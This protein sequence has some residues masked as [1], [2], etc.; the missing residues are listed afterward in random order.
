MY[1][2]KI[3]PICNQ[4]FQP[5]FAKQKY[6]KRPVELT[7]SVC[8][9]T[10]IG[11]CSPDNVTVCN[12]PE[13][14]KKAAS[15]GATN[16]T[17]I[18]RICGQPFHPN[19][20]RQ[21]D[22][23]RPVTKV[24]VLC[25]KEYVGKCSQNDLSSTCSD[26][27]RIK[28]A[29]QQ[30]MKA[31]S[32]VSTRT[33]ML[34]GKEFHPVNNTQIIC[35]DDHFRTC[36]VCGKEF[37]LDTRY[38]SR[39]WATTCSRNCSAILAN[40]NKTAETNARIIEERRADRY[41]DNP[42][43]LENYNMF[44]K[45]PRGYILSRY[46]KDNPATIYKLCDDFMLHNT[47]VGVLIEKY[48][49]RDLLKMKTSTMEQE[50]MRFIESVSPDI[51]I[52][53]NTR[54][55]ITPYELDIYLPDY[56]FAIEC[57]PTATHNSTNHP[58]EEDALPTPEKYHKM[59]TDMCEPKGIY[60]LHVFG[61][62]WANKK[63]IIK[64][65]IC[66]AIRHDDKIYAR[67]CV[68]KEVNSSEARA[69]L[70]ENHRQGHCGSS[71]R[72]GLYYQDKL[73]S[74]MTFGSPR[75]GIGNNSQ[76]YELLRFCSCKYMSVVGGASKLFKYFIRTYNPSSIISYSDRAHTT[77]NIYKVL[78]FNEICRSD[79]NYRWVQEKTDKDYHRIN[80]QKQN[81]KQ[82]LKDDTIDLSET[83]VK[84]M[85]SHGYVQVFDSGTITWEWTK[86]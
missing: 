1:H 41:K 21:L 72:I 59:K 80:A 67:N 50:I 44:L 26:E 82:F 17:K 71:I 14:K 39:E 43:K 42:D 32:R 58:F 84:I 51:K 86:D 19:S 7:C 16:K 46:S 61:Y 69:F 54:K 11:Q 27:C 40:R 78:G 76:Q 55:I 83:E 2:S 62:D 37:K 22:C 13:C 24:C 63:E 60:L 34:C 35:K 18:C 57:N 64:S 85:A 25:G 15:V 65:I 48:G 29:S 66:N 6:C 12:K 52:V 5:Q 73:V 81:I 4:E 68:I 8:G 79:A 49:L 30:S 47:T 77:G 33:C 36:E 45:D 38:N 23:N 75:R 53:H 31:V 20:S 10:Y 56:N 74:L 28:Y 3:C 9:D 70:D